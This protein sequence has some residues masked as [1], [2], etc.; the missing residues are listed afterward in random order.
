MFAGI[1]FL[2]SCIERDEY[3]IEP[4]IEFSDFYVMIDQ[5]S[6][7]EIGV[8]VLK[9][10]DGDGDIGLAPKDTLYPYQLDG[11]YYYNY[12]MYFYKK[13][14][15]NFVKIETPYNIRIPIIN[16]DD[17]AQNLDGEIYIDIDLD[18]LR[19]AITDGVFKFD[20]FIYDRALNKSNT[21]TSPVIQLD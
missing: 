4:Y 20:A 8:I 18:I 6:G 12:I 11:D 9:F 1:L 3:P 5:A 15:T 2:Q 10:T 17:F 21:I 19:T 16:P 7:K 13:Q 14:G